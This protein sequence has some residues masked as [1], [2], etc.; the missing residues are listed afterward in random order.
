MPSSSVLPPLPVKM[1]YQ[2]LQLLTA[3]APAHPHVK[4]LRAKFDE[5]LSALPM[6]VQWRVL[7][8]GLS[9]LEVAHDA[10]MNNLRKRLMALPDAERERIMA[11]VLSDKAQRDTGG[12]PDPL[13]EVILTWAKMPTLPPDAEDELMRSHPEIRDYILG[14]LQILKTTQKPLAELTEADLAPL[15][16]AH[17]PLALLAVAEAKELPADF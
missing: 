7:T 12:G 14:V 2:M 1:L 5:A 6:A 15:A 4:E 9:L 11:K 16:E 17:R 10:D 13:T 3:P 8:A